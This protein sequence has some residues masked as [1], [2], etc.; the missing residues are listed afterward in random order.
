MSG[1]GFTASGDINPSR[2]AKVSG[3]LKVA[4]CDAN[5]RSVGISAEFTEA[6]PIPS[7]ST[8]HATSG[9]PAHIHGIG[10]VCLLTLGSGGATAGDLLK[11]DADGKGVAIAT[12]GT[13][14]QYAGAQA[15]ETGVENDKVRVRVLPPTPIRP[16]LA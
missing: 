5:E 6:A 9:N 1:P 12:T 3:N 8:L 11:P 13:T 16:A 4:E 7:A 10:E 14:I 2:F 15:L